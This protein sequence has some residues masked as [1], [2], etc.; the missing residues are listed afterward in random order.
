[1]LGRELQ[2]SVVQA[3][4]PVARALVHSCTRAL[5]CWPGTRPK[6]CGLAIHRHDYPC[7]LGIP[8]SPYGRW[9]KLAESSSRS[10]NSSSRSSS[11]SISSSSSSISSKSLHLG[12]NYGF[13]FSHKLPNH[14]HQLQNH[15]SNQ[16]QPNTNTSTAP[17]VPPLRN[18]K[19]KGAGRKNEIKFLFLAICLKFVFSWPFRK[20]K[21]IWFNSEWFFL[22]LWISAEWDGPPL[23]SSIAPPTNPHTSPRP[24]KWR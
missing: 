21:L 11:R 6:V 4:A 2:T 22:N 19:Y 17:P 18:K 7:G 5:I 12:A 15:H 13:P 9:P 23:E 3:D 8:G 16:Y 10:S 24:E 1:M 20:R 14:Q